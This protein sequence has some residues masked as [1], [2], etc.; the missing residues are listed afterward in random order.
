MAFK[1]QK[2]FEITV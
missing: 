1:S 2:Q